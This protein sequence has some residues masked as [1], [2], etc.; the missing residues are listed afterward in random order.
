MQKIA[1]V[2]NVNVDFQ[3]NVD[4]MKFPLI[5]KYDGTT[6]HV[7]KRGLKK[8]SKTVSNNWRN[9]SRIVGNTENM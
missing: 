5:S 1:F 6:E 3:K 2:G 9:N 7:V 4:D 8:L